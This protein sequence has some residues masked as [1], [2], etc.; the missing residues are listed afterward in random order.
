MLEDILTDLRNNTKEVEIRETTLFEL[1]PLYRVTYA[2]P[3]F[4]HVEGLKLQ[5]KYLES[6][7]IRI[8]VSES[9]SAVTAYQRITDGFEK[10]F[11]LANN[12][13]KFAN[14]ARFKVVHSLS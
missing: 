8:N 7:L 12:A 2:Q 13:S 10:A 5:A 4:D 11:Q 9:F 1:V 14:D 6:L 3:A